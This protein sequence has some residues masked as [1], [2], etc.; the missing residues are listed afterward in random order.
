[1]GISGG[2]GEGEWGGVGVW[3]GEG[4]DVVNEV[5]VKEWG[6]GFRE[7]QEKLMER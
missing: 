6:W 2:T 3:G 5:T 1:M 4:D 7:V